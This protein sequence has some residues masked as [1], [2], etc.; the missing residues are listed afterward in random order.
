MYIY[1]YT[2]GVCNGYLMW[3]YNWQIQQLTSFTKQKRTCLAMRCGIHQQI[4]MD[5]MRFFSRIHDDHDGLMVYNGI[6]IMVYN[7]I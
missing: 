3:E 2:I 6:N 5:F 7:G 1:I 4:M